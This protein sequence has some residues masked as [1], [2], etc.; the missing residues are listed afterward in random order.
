MAN[1][2]HKIKLLLLWDILCKYT[3]ESH[4]LNT[5]EIIK[6]LADKGIN[7]SRKILSQ[8]IALLNDSGYE[9]LSYKKKYYYYYVVN[10]PFDTAEIVMLSD[11]VKA[12][13]LTPTQK[14]VLVERLSSFLCSHQAESVSK[15]II[16]F[17]KSRKGSSLLYTTWTQ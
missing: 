7:V 11:V 14:K 9:I 6:M 16:S 5:D 8:D 13:K 17:E 10:R 2:T 4:H 15:H 3:D 1:E 12:S